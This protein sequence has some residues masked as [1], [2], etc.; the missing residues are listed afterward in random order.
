M[1]GERRVEQPTGET[2][3]AL[4]GATKAFVNVEHGLYLATGAVVAIIAVMALAAAVETLWAA[5][6]H[7]D[8]GSG[9]L[10]VMDQLLFVLMLAEILHTVSVSIRSGTLTCEPF[11]TVGL[12]A[13]IRRVLVITLKSSQLAEG[14]SAGDAAFQSSMI[15]LGVLAGLI[16]IMVAS[17]AMLR[18]A[19]SEDKPVEAK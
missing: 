12:I 10:Q 6:R 17:I 11:L 5:V 14:A 9:L 13:S 19:R 16:L 8:A 15:E 1:D 4:R 3:P 18:R 2:R 7:W